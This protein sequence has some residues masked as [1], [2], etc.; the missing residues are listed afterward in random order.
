MKRPALEASGGGGA[1]RALQKVGQLRW[2]NEAR[3]AKNLRT[4]TKSPIAS[5]ADALKSEPTIASRPPQPPRPS[6]LREDDQPSRRTLMGRPARAA[7]DR[8]AEGIASV[9]R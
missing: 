3:F 8:P 2:E 7:E 6:H 4:S 5:V 9:V 1:L